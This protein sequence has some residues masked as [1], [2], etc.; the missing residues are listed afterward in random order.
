MWGQ[1]GRSSDDQ[2]YPLVFDHSA[3]RDL[4][5]MRHGKVG[6]SKRFLLMLCFDLWGE[7]KLEKA[8]K[9]MRAFQ[10]FLV[11]GEEDCGE[12]SGSG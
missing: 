5:R 9:L 6:P 2:Q 4:Q 7:L 3:D 12:T 1:L 10:R 8:R 11:G